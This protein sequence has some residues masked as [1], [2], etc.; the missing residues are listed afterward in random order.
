MY[1]HAY[2][3][4]V[5]VQN[6]LSTGLIGN[7]LREIFSFEVFFKELEVNKDEKEVKVVKEI[8]DHKK[9]LEVSK[10]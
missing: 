9:N 8:L 2:A 4:F 7:I 5:L 3:L 10:S 6:I 1:I